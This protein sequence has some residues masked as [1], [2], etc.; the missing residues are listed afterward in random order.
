M[1]Y[2]VR[3]KRSINNLQHFI[4]KSVYFIYSTAS[5]RLITSPC[6]IVDHSSEPQS[7]CSSVHL[8]IT[9]PWTSSSLS[10]VPRRAFSW[11][12]PT[13]WKWQRS[14]LA[15]SQT[16]RLCR[17]E[18]WEKPSPGQ[19]DPRPCPRAKPKCNSGR[20]RWRR[21][22]VPWPLARASAA[23]WRWSGR[24]GWRSR[25]AFWLR[26]DRLSRLA[27][28]DLGL[29]RSRAAERS[30]CGHAELRSQRFPPRRCS[31]TCSPR[32]RQLEPEY[33]MRKIKTWSSTLHQSV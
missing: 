10:A 26:S 7:K 5:Y 9:P 24:R 14:S 21:A 23:C 33:L 22:P 20:S 18:Y 13:S 19:T 3:I 8:M 17:G 28:A 25:R 15:A 16:A 6:P 29:R 12:P 1:Q 31:G 30:W 11:L 32:S 27:R 2:S 4:N